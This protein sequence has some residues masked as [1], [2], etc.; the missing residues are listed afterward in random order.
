MIVKKTYLVLIIVFITFAASA[1]R[2]GWEGSYNRLGIQAGV[3]HFNIITDDFDVTAKTSWT[4][5]FT[6]RSSFYDDFQFVL[7]H[8]LL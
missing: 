1:Q 8:Q 5:G 4:A 7:W 6:T 2:R 3:N